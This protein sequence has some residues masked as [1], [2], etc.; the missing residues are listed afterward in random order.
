MRGFISIQMDG[1]HSNEFTIFATLT[2]QIVQ[3]LIQNNH[4]AVET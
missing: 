2:K 1:R 4:V 3:T